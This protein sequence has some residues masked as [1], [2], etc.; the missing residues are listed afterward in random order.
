MALGGIVALDHY[1]WC[2]DFG[3]RQAYWNECRAQ[4]R[5]PDL[6]RDL[7]DFWRPDAPSRRGFE[8]AHQV[9]DSKVEPI[10]RDFMS[11]DLESLGTFDVVLFLGVPYHLKDPVSAVERLRRPATQVAVIETEAVHDDTSLMAFC[12]GDELGADYG[13]WYV[14]TESAARPLP[15]GW[16]LESGDGPPPPLRQPAPEAERNGPGARGQA[17]PPGRPRISLVGP[18]VWVGANHR[19]QG[20][21]S[22]LRWAVVRRACSSCCNSE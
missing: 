11:M 13:N 10:I 15:G 7:K 21:P 17:L 6:D 4:G 16:V 14:P 5:I 2:L 19:P 18:S 3:A 12:P 8:I 20:N 1:A 22:N 9:L